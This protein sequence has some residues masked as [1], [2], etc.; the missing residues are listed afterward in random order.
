MHSQKVSFIIP[1]YNEECRIAES[2]DALKSFFDGFAFDFEIIFVDDGSRD[3]TAQIIKDYI[4]HNN[5]RKFRILRLSENKGKGAAVKTGMLNADTQ[6]FLFFFMDADLSTPLTEINSFI[7]LFKS[8]G[9]DIIIGSRSLPQSKI[10]RRQNYV[11]QSMGKIFNAIIR[12]IADIHFIDTQCGFKMFNAAA[13]N[14]IF[15]N[16][17]TCGFSFDV[18][19]VLLAKKLGLTIIDAPVTWI[20]NPHSKVRIL[21]DSIKML[22]DVVKIKYLIKKIG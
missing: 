14:S 11:R 3:N 18:E 21:S 20:N 19:I 8:R 10:V 7:E 9:V 4:H 15:A 6:S 13:K 12:L 2:L 22:I 5:I 16:L 17:Q 1:V